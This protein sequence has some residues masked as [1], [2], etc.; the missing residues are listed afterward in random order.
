MSPQCINSINIYASTH[1]GTIC[2]HLLLKYMHKL[3]AQVARVQY[4]T[5]WFS[6]ERSAFFV[7]DSMWA[8]LI[9][10]PR[11]QTTHHIFDTKSWHV[12]SFHPGRFVPPRQLLLGHSCGW[13]SKSTASTWQDGLRPAPSGTIC[14]N[15]VGD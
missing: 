6:G 1:V 3:K 7:F 11:K 14:D 9:D 2:I 13:P 4:Q 10:D 12:R 5:W 15:R 8:C